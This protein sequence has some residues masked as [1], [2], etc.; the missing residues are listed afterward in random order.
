MKKIY[1]S[2]MLAA[3]F[4]LA[5]AIEMP[6]YTG[7]CNIS[8]YDYSTICGIPQW[9]H[10]YGSPLGISSD[11]ACT[12]Y[13]FFH[14]YDGYTPGIGKPYVIHNNKS[15]SINGFKLYYYFTA[16]PSRQFNVKVYRYLYANRNDRGRVMVDNSIQPNNIQVEKLSETQY[17]AILNYSNVYIARSSRFPAEGGI[18]IRVASADS[19][20]IDGY[21]LNGFVVESLSGSV[22]YGPNLNDEGTTTH[23]LTARRIGVLT[24]ES[25]CPDYSSIKLDVEDSD[26]QTSITYVG[27]ASGNP[28]GIKKERFYLWFKYCGLSYSQ[29]PQTR[30]GYAVLKLDSECPAGSLPIVRTHDTED[31]NN[32]DSYTG[33]IWPNSV[34]QGSAHAVLQYCYVPS[35]AGSSVMYPFD[36][37]YGVFASKRAYVVDNN[38]I[39]VSRVFVDDENNANQNAWDRS[40]VPLHLRS[41][42]QDIMTGAEDTEYYVARW[43]G[44]ENAMLA[45]SADAVRA[46]N[47][48]VESSLVAAAP[49]APAIKGLNRNVVAVELKS[50]GDAKVS[51]VGINGA[52]VANVTEKNLQPG[53]HQIKWNAG[54]VPSGRYVVKIEQNGM[55]S[56]KN[57]ILK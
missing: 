6:T 2:M 52:V 21:E 17:R 26:N 22:L 57:V 16:P 45:K 53:V 47:I 11:N 40:G 43:V 12:D 36:K 39:S 29:L 1:L 7:N 14:G 31:I 25:T 48:S 50:A 28:I 30:F 20:G 23:P 49:L 33:Y 8:G 55:V 3:S 13:Q 54:I 41:S 15:Q 4:G 10:V 9:I 46:D 18:Y 56:A 5:N 37:K 32:Y 24:D 27:G 34:A 42:S 35:K 19:Y 38:N 51:I 44:P